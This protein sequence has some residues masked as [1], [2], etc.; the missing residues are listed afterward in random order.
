[1]NNLKVVNPKIFESCQVNLKFVKI[2]PRKV[3]TSTPILTLDNSI[4]SFDNN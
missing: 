1:M 4:D 2:V 3:H